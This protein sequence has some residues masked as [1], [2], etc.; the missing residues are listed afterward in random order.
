MKTWSVYAAGVYVATVTVP[1][2]MKATAVREAVVHD[3]TVAM[4]LEVAE[5][6]HTPPLPRQGRHAG[7]AARE[8]VMTDWRPA[9]LEELA[10]EAFTPPF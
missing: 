3:I 2:D 10:P 9:S 6:D 1:D 7:A 4:D 5:S 8:R